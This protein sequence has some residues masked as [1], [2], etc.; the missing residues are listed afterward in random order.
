VEIET[1]KRE[2]KRIEKEIEKKVEGTETIVETEIEKKMAETEKKKVRRETDTEKRL[3]TEEIKT[4]ETVAI[5][6]G[7]EMIIN[8]AK[9]AEIKWLMMMIETDIEIVDKEVETVQDTENKNKL[10]LLNLIFIFI[11]EMI[12][13]IHFKRKQFNFIFFW[14]FRGR[15]YKNIFGAVRKRITI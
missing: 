4:K 8:R 2:V 15:F 12:M 1:G 7:I 6:T 9:I 5:L 13:E 14:Q 10:F 11:N 3:K